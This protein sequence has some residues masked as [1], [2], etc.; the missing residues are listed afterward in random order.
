[1][2]PFAERGTAIRGGVGGCYQN[3]IVKKKEAMLREIKW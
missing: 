1:M 2:T 3:V